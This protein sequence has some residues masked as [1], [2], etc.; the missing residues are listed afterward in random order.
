MSTRDMPEYTGCRLVTS[1]GCTYCTD[2]MG[3]ALHT[4]LAVKDSGVPLQG[5]MLQEVELDRELG[6]K[7]LAEAEDSHT[8][9]GAGN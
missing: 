4:G 9:R 8:A 3:L 1:T 2:C 6:H 7:R 5:H